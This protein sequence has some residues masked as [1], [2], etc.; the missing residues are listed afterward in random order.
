METT[1]YQMCIDNVARH[2]RNHPALTNDSVDAFKASTVLAIAFCKGKE[3]VISDILI[4][5]YPKVE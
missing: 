5:T 4:A 1:P 2:I 3:E